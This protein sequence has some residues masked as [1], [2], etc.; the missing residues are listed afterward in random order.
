MSDLVGNP[1][2]RFSRVAAHLMVY[3]E[4]DFIVSSSHEIGQFKP[5]ILKMHFHCTTN[6]NNIIPYVRNIIILL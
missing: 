3:C 1:K 6:Y 5:H 2:D 4:T